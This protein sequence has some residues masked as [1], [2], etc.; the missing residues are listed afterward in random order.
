M[1]RENEGKKR[2][3]D[4]IEKRRKLEGQQERQKEKERRNREKY[5]YGME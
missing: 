1:S 3:K 2:R 5:G 4:M